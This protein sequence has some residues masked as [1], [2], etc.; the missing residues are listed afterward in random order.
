MVTA[1]RLAERRA[2]ITRSPD[3]QALSAHLLA[4]N[5]R[6]ATEMPPL[7]EV[8]ALLSVDGGRCPHDGS[9]LTFDPWNGEEHVCA[10]CGARVRGERHTR[11]WAKSQHLWLVE[12]ATEL[13]ALSGL[14]DASLAARAAEILR[15]YGDRY[16]RYPN[17]DNVLGPSRLFFSTYLE[18]IWI[19]NYL[20]AA[21]LLRES[22]SLDEA[23]AR[24]VHTVADEAANLIGEYDEGFSNRQTWNDAALCA[25]AVWFEDEELARRAIEGGTG[26]LAHLRGYRDDGLWYEGENYHLFALRGLLTG[27]A[28][29]AEAGVDLFAETA[30]AERLAL[31]LR[32]PALTALPDL[33][34]PARKDSRFGLSLAQSPFLELWEVGIAR[35]ENAERERVEPERDLIPW[36]H[37]LYAAGPVRAELFES[38]LH[39]A[40]LDPLPALPTRQRL[41]WWALLEMLPELPASKDAWMPR[42]VFLSGQG[43][44]VLRTSGRYAALECGGTGGGHGHPDRLNLLLHADGVYWLPDAGTGSYVAR[45]LQWY[46]STLAHNAPRLDGAS[47]A[48]GEARGEGFE[49][50]GDWGWAR[51]RFGPFT[52]TVVMGPA[53]LLDLVEM[54]GRDERVIELPFHFAG[55]GDVLTRGQWE[56]ADLPGNEFVTR[57]ERFRPEAADP[58][59]LALEADHRSL[60]AH[61]VF[62]GELLRAQGPSGVFY[63]LRAR[64]RNP[65]L[66]SVL[67]FGGPGREVRQVR[68]RGDMVEV[69]GEWGTDRHRYGGREWEIV[70]QDGTMT[71]AALPVVQERFEPL[72]D[73]EP[74]ARPSGAALRVDAPPPLDG[75]T[76]GFDMTEPLRLDLEDQYRR[77]EEAYAGPEDFSATCAANWDDDALYLAVQVTKPDVCVRPRDAP[78]LRLDNEPDD[79][80]SDGLQV[81]VGREE[82]ETTTPIGFLIVPESEGGTLRISRADETG[83]EPTAVR[84]G[85]RRTADGYVVTLA[86][87]WPQELVMHVGGRVGFDLIVNEMLPGRERR[88][89]QLVWSGGNGWVW[90]Q[91]DRQDPRRFGVLELVG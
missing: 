24:A 27:A 78:P 53:Y 65:R 26:L 49:D 73:L 13:A 90:L 47:Q 32:A 88:A 46:R 23:T 31:A 19:L 38:Y 67:Q 37:A 12:R 18:S 43:L 45:D 25:I 70:G 10:E 58:L 33:T 71:L 9:P 82:G 89:G 16:F 4:R 50:R 75:T 48:P 72:L 91:G 11:A 40:P 56:A 85:W 6:V 29:A 64:G 68:S 42:G 77:S 3:L 59:V 2:E 51:G 81:Y 39:D 8:K 7:P 87:A 69:E 17:R 5:A 61:F 62:D 15:G 66:T 1:E 41:S 57:V 21:M 28:W 76:A 86:I 63:A 80:H 35:L 36:V 84:G 54:T 14:G 30:T 44:A 52:R 79:I 22:G 34:Y 74:P 20:A 83:G 60:K 55:R